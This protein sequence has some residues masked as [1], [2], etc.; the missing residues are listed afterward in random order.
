MAL[1]AEAEE[2]NC[3]ALSWRHEQAQAEV[4]D[5]EKEICNRGIGIV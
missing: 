2:E 1:P 3:P 5:I 4:G